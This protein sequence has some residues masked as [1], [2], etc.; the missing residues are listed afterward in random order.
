MMDGH[1]QVTEDSRTN[2]PRDGDD[3]VGRTTMPSLQ[4]G[5]GRGRPKLRASATNEFLV[6]QRV[7]GK[8]G[9]LPEHPA[10]KSGLRRRV[11]RPAVQ[12]HQGLTCYQCRMSK[13]KCDKKDPCGRCERLGIRCTPQ[14]APKKRQRKKSPNGSDAQG[15]TEEFG[16]PDLENFSIDRFRVNLEQTV[17]QTGMNHH[18]LAFYAL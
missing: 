6:E 12:Q 15:Q 1:P 9:T 8:K 14:G 2:H 16:F 3:R 4:S 11:Q 17:L 10:Q 7:Q 5:Q 18:H 13:V